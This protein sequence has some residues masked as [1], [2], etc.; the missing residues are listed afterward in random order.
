MKLNRFQR[1]AIQSYSASDF[2]FLLGL[3]GKALER[4]LKSCTDAFFLSIITEL[5]DEEGCNT[6]DQAMNRCAAMMRDINAICDQIELGE[7]ILPA[8]T[9][10]VSEKTFTASAFDH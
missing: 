9:C 6:L 3:E 5:G 4:A 7:P 2:G 1:A 10:N 8:A